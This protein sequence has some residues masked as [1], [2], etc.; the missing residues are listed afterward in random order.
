[1]IELVGSGKQLR[2]IGCGEV[3]RETSREPGGR[4]CSRQLDGLT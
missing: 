4:N 2:R 3:G 1:M